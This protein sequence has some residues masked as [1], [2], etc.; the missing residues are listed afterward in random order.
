MKK[1]DRSWIGWLMAMILVA[2]A[3]LLIGY[4]LGSE[5]GKKE[6]Y[7]LKETQ[8]PPVTEE[9]DVE[10][11]VVRK[12][13]T[14][15]PQSQERDEF[16]HPLR[17]AISCDQIEEDIRDF[18]K[19]LNSKSYVRHLDEKMDTRVVFKELVDKFSR[20]PPIPAGEGIDTSIITKNIFYF[21]RLLDKK[22]IRLIRSIIRNE[23]DTMEM[24]LD[25]FYQWFLLGAKCPNVEGLR[26]SLNTLYQYAG[27]FLN[28]IGGRSYLF[29]R[30]LGL[31]IL[32]S[33]Y[34]ISII[35]EA[36]KQGKNSYGID[37]FPHIAPL[38]KEIIHYPE[39]HFKNEY[40]QRLTKI[41]NYY[42]A[43]R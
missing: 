25:L 13:V 20:N 40:V 3:A 16:K 17:Q 29:R 27:F 35:H 6:H 10:L 32:V 19:Y 7:A 38:A 12:P 23:A 41:S 24:N 30:P 22:E 5:K 43:T 18:F 31:R 4:H 1:R 11:E 34:S 33:Y 21:F 36:D 8:P 2:A 28:S 9:K 14:E 39:F 42:M 15:E 26:P 37:V